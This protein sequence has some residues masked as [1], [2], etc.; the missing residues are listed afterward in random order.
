MENLQDL[1]TLMSD[2][3]DS[4]RVDRSL[5]DPLNSVQ[6][7]LSVLMHLQI[8][9]LWSVQEL[10]I[11]DLNHSKKDLIRLS[12]GHQDLS[13]LKGRNRADLKLS[14]CNSNLVRK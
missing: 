12:E 2:R 8:H 5:Q 6:I 4:G 1:Q 14:R 3:K 11:N 9:S 7:R 10:K 13:R